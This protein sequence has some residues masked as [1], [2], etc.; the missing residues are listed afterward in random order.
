MSGASR[1]RNRPGADQQRDILESQKGACF[2]CRNVFGQY[3]VAAQ[4]R[5]P[6][7]LLIQWDHRKP[8]A[9]DQDNGDQNF[10]AACTLCNRWKTD[11]MPDA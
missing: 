1:R 3:V 7:Q 9:Y 11:L 4:W 8:Y 6:R 2:W 10:V 5:R